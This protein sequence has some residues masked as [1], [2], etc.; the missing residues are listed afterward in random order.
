[1]RRNPLRSQQPADALAERL[2]GQRSSLV[3]CG[4]WLLVLLLVNTLLPRGA[5]SSEEARVWSASAACKDDKLPPQGVYE[6]HSLKAD[7]QHRLD[8]IARGGFKVV[9][10]YAAVAPWADPDVNMQQI[11]AYADHAASNGLQVIWSLKDPQWWDGTNLLSVFPGLASQLGAK[12]NAEFI[13]NFVGALKNHP[14][15]W[16]YYVAD[17][18]GAT[19]ATQVIA[20]ADAIRAA[21]PHHPTLTVHMSNQWRDGTMQAFERAAS[22]IGFDH[23]PIGQYEGARQQYEND[24]VRMTEVV[25]WIRGLNTNAAVN[26]KALVV[27]LQAHDSCASYPSTCRWYPYSRWP[28]DDEMTDLRDHVLQIACSNGVHVSLILWYSF[29]DIM[30]HNPMAWRALISGAFAPARGVPPRPAPAQGPA[31]GPGAGAGGALPRFGG[32]SPAD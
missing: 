21:D 6:L 14:A 29:F 4:Q 22:H 16:G 15:T 9:L 13:M 31:Q 17:E 19:K 32:K 18:S 11:K 3:I 25:G 24:K 26:P 28:T 23:Y 20:I 30:E 10:N 27:A 2:F 1:M 12:S 8:L 7:G 5:T